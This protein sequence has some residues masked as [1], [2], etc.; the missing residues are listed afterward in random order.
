MSTMLYFLQ[1]FT[2]TL[3]RLSPLF[4]AVGLSPLSKFP[5]MVRLI[6]LIFLSIFLTSLS[7]STFPIMSTSDWVVGLGFE[8]TL[9]ML[10]L[11]G[12]QLS[13]AAIQVIGKVLDMQIGFAA[14]GVIDPVSSS[15]DPLIGSM[16][17][18]FVTL[19]IFLTGTH[20]QILYSLKDLISLIPPGSWNG[21]MSLDRI[22]AFFSTQMMFAM[23]ILG[24]VIMGL[25]LLDVF[26]GFIA[27][28]MPQMNV[29]F[30][31][32]PLKIAVGI[33]LMSVVMSETKPL[34]QGVYG[35]LVNWFQLGWVT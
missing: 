5:A 20:Y 1:P 18:L 13:F 11:L 29:Y 35:E 32:L 33:F 4:L 28:T 9:G 10:M 23:L 15:N 34:L 22:L 6:L 26:N 2:L 27:K 16:L 21:S 25:W 30:V 17:V 31:L 3:F 14:A 8:W 12:F 24:P 7:T 19:S